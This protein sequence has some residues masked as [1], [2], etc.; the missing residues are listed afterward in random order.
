MENEVS[1]DQRT[2]INQGGINYTLN[3]EDKT[4]EVSVNSCNKS[5]IIFQRSINYKSTEYIITKVNSFHADNWENRY[6]QFAPD[7]EIRTIDQN[8]FKKLYIVSVTFS[9]HLTRICSYAF[10]DCFY[11]C[12]VIFPENSELQVIEKFAFIN[13]SIESILIPSTVTELQEGFLCKNKYLKKIQVMPGNRYYKSYE[14]KFLFKK[15]DENEDEFDVLI[16][17][18]KDVKTVILPDYIKRISGYSFNECQ[19]L[20]KIEVSKDSKLQTIGEFAFYESSIECLKIPSCFRNFE[21]GWNSST[22]KLI[23]VSIIGDNLHYKIYDDNFLVEKNDQ[24]KAEF[25][26]LV[27][28]TR[29]SNRE[30]VTIPKFINKIDCFAFEFC[31]NIKEVEIL[32]NSKLQII[33]QFAFSKS[34]IEKISLS[35]EIK[36]ILRN[37]F[38]FCKELQTV[39][40]PKNSKLEKM[41]DSVFTGSS[42]ER[43][44]IPPHLTEISQCTFNH[45]KKLKTIE[46]LPNSELRTIGSYA[47]IQSSI[48]SITIPPHLTEINQSSFH[49]CKK[50]QEVV[51]QPNSELKIIGEKAFYGTSIVNITIPPHVTSICDSAFN[52]CFDLR[53]VKFMENSE[54]T[55]IGNSMFVESKIESFTI[56]PHV[57]KIARKT[58]S[59]CNSL[60]EVKI[61]ENSELK[62]IEE[63]AFKDSTIRELSIPSSFVEFEEGWCNNTKNL[64]KITVMPRNSLYKEYEDKFILGKSNPDSNEFDTLVFCSRNI[65]K[66]TI[67]EIIL[68]IKPYAFEHCSKLQKI[69]FSNKSRL[70]IIEKCAFNDCDFLKISIPRSVTKICKD[71]FAYCQNLNKFVIEKKSELNLI[72]PHAFFETSFVGFEVPDHLK[73]LDLDIFINC[74]NLRIVGI[75]DDSELTKIVL[76]MYH[77]SKIILYAPKKL[78]GFFIIED[79]DEIWSESF[80]QA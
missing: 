37:C 34:S 40:I 22:P 80:E 75:S 32:E 68:I 79:N 57:T 3:D 30:K 5:T 69:E 66:V 47:F 63:N 64:F 19:Q 76:N 50:L 9:P 67:P 15:S 72:E 56:P 12:E 25:D 21:R 14:D 45:C 60:Q 54:L 33:G 53:E 13:T 18:A 8:V 58:F 73:I 43:F 31:Q 20:Q 38:S 28:Y 39:E 71:A 29:K 48:E 44:T 74:P 41:D 36:Q 78:S 55:E 11:L 65:E 7:S 24:E 59:N 10:S 6:I 49:F 16:L 70:Q 26:T 4:A 61:S 42:I 62:T 77:D 52:D 51:I 27:F 35:S 17:A 1:E 2:I 46:I 23:S